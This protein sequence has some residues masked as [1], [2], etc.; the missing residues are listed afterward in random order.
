MCE[1]RPTE[2]LKTNVMIAAT[3]APLQT[4]DDHHQ[5]YS[6]LTREDGF[7]IR[8]NE[9]YFVPKQQIKNIDVNLTSPQYDILYVERLW[10]DDYGVGQAAGFYYIRPNETFH[11]PN[12]K[13]FYN[14]VFRFPS[15]NDPLPISCFVR[16][17]YVFDIAT[18]CK[19]KPI[20][21]NSSRVLSSDLFICENRVDKTARTFSRLAKSRY[22]AINSKTY[23][24]DS[25]VEKL[26]VKRDYQV[27][28]VIWV[29]SIVIKR[30]IDM[31][32]SVELIKRCFF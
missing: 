24:F 19:G 1:Q 13:F 27:S 5:S 12:R 7:I 6:T 4:F 8:I 21:D 3:L 18:Y 30:D 23:C 29:Y 26:V 22:F 25:Y 9:C 28:I 32:F 16:P 2:C 20:S 15:S 31:I 10:N 17:C 11:E 14:E